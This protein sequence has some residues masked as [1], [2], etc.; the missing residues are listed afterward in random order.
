MFVREKHLKHFALTKKL[1]VISENC[2]ACFEVP[3]ERA[4]IKSLLSTQELYLDTLFSS[5]SRAMIPLMS[6]GT[7]NKDLQLIKQ[8]PS[9]EDLENEIESLKKK[10][11]EKE[12]LLQS[13]KEKK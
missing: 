10:L 5:L 3:K 8:K 13:L 7:P 11:Y 9:V 2:P 1:P 6:K 12:N 4:R